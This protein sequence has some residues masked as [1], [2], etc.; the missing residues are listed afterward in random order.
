M[1]LENVQRTVPRIVQRTVPRKRTV[2]RMVQRTVPRI[3][4]S[5]ENSPKN[6]AENSPKNSAENSL[7]NSAE[8]VPKCYNFSSASTSYLHDG[9]GDGDGGQNDGE[10]GGPA[11]TAAAGSWV[12]KT[13]TQKSEREH[14]C[15]SLSAMIVMIG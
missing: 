13:Q 5:V 15:L 8:N 3:K 7:K 9:D 10:V 11:S 6:S 4:N 14:D 2:P 1:K 12:P